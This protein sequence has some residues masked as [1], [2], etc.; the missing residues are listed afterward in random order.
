MTKTNPNQHRRQVID[1]EL[2]FKIIE[3]RGYQRMP[4]VPSMNALIYEKVKHL[5]V[6]PPK[7]R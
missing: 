7:R 4:E 6:D 5:Y 2:I 3:D 1:L